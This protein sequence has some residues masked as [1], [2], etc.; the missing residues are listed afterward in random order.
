M[1]G[2]LESVGR[3]PGLAAVDWASAS[4]GLESKTVRPSAQ[5]RRREVLSRARAAPLTPTL[6]PVLWWIMVES[7]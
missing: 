4:A 1:M 5:M 2:S 7:S 3:A 6:G